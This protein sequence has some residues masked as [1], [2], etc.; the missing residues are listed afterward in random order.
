M[1]DTTRSPVHAAYFSMLD[2]RRLARR[3]MVTAFL[4]LSLLV[5][6]AGT[7]LAIH[8]LADADGNVE[9]Y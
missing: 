3:L 7:A 5:A 9:G 1:H 2:R 6:G 8:E 4:A